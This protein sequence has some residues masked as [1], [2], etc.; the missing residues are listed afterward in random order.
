[1]TPLHRLAAYS[2]GLLLLLLAYQSLWGP[3]AWVYNDRALVSPLIPSLVNGRPL[4]AATWAMTETPMAARLLNL[5][6]HAGNVL[7]VVLLARRIG[8]SEMVATAAAFAW[9]VHPMQV[10]TVAYAAGRS[11]LLAATG[12]LI[13]ALAALANGRGWGLWAVVG[14]GLGLASKESAIVALGLIPLVRVAVGHAWRLTGAV[15]GLAVLAG[16]AWFGGPTGIIERELYSTHVSMLDWLLLQA[17]ATARLAWLALVPIG[18]TLDFDYDL[19][20][21]GVRALCVVALLGMTWLAWSLRRSAP[22]VAV[23]LAWML[24]AVLPRLVVQTPRSYLNEHQF[25]VPLLGLAIVAGDGLQR[26]ARGYGRVCG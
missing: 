26:W 8:L 23:G 15:C 22:L 18:Q 24:I 10:E 17:T 2:G 21:V 11:E 3:A 4:A 16:V 19:I 20:P 7:L 14:V 13:A 6:L 25:Y 1:M 5:L 9:M 12:V